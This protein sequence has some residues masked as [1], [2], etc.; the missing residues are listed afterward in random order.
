M[1]LRIVAFYFSML[2]NWQ[3]HPLLVGPYENLDECQSVR[4][5]LDRRSYET[6]DCAYMT[7]PQESIYLEVGYLPYED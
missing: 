5:F 6:S 1:D 2:V 3:E 4:E 7:Y